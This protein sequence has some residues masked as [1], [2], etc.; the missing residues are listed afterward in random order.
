[1]PASKP[2]RPKGGG[3]LVFII[4]AALALCACGSPAPIPTRAPGPTGGHLVLIG[5]GKKPA[6]VMKRFV[7]LGGGGDGR[8]VVLPLASGDS[9]DTGAY[10]VDLLRRHGARRVRV[11]HIDD[12]RDAHRAIYADAI[13]GATGVF[14]TGGDQRRIAS[15]IVGT[16]V[17][18]ALRDMHR[19]GGVVGGTSAGTACQTDVMLTGDGD[20]RRQ[21]RGNVGVARGLGL[22]PGVVVD[23]HFSQRRR[24]R[25]LLSVVLEHPDQVGVG[26]DEATAAVVAPDGSVRA[27]G[28]GTITIYD[29]RRARIHTAA[30]GVMRADGV[31]T[32]TLREKDGAYAP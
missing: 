12:R 24:Q 29:A 1:M 3:E 11:V 32:Q 22:W 20:P 16:P 13:R 5:G 10:Y 8:F 23:Q 31:T 15:R 17:H 18:A 27:V 7:D 9:R 21:V 30:T 2:P 14:F 26:I 25:R 28:E 4:A 19:R 6:R